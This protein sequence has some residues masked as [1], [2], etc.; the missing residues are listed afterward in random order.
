MNDKARRGGV[1]AANYVLHIPRE[2]TAPKVGIV[3]T[4]CNRRAVDVNCVETLDEIE[5]N[6]DAQ[7]RVCMAAWRRRG[8]DGGIQ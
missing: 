8:G 5:R 3:F 2:F 4:L 7:C 6:P 1:R